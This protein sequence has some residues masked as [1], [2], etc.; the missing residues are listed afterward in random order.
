MLISDIMRYEDGEII[1]RGFAKEW[2]SPMQQYHHR[3]L[4]WTPETQLLMRVQMLQNG[5]VTFPPLAGHPFDVRPM[6]N[7]IWRDIVTLMFA[8]CQLSARRIYR[9]TS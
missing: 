9:G 4:K 8:S 5:A 2:T 3:P 6:P 7:R 1:C